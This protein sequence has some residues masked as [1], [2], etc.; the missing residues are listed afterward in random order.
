MASSG[1]RSCASGR[2]DRVG[3]SARVQKTLTCPSQA[4]LGGEVRAFKSL[5]AVAVG[6]DLE[7]G[8]G[9]MDVIH[10]DFHAVPFPTASFDYAL[11]AP[12]GPAVLDRP[13]GVGL[14]ATSGPRAFATR[15]VPEGGAMVMSRSSESPKRP[16]APRWPS[17]AA[18][19]IRTSSITCLTFTALVTRP[20]AH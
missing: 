14:A 9:N 19:G 3:A 6:I 1:G 15:L 5:G 10:G 16:R 2:G 4:R 7:P 12:S 11:A 17:N 18:A 8:R 20:H 13:R